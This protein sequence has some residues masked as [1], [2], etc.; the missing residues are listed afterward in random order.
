MENS[1]EWLMVNVGLMSQMHP[2]QCGAEDITRAQMKDMCGEPSFDHSP[3]LLTTMK[4]E[5]TVEDTWHVMMNGVIAGGHGDFNQADRTEDY[6]SVPPADYPDMS[7]YDY[8][9]RSEE[10]RSIFVN[11]FL[12]Y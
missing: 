8:K 7:N 11:F 1:A 5:T 2:F 4:D 10:I 6:D 3:G 12:F 9:S